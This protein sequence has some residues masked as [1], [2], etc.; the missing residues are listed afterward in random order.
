MAGNLSMLG[1]EAYACEH[2]RLH[3]QA[4]AFLQKYFEISLNRVKVNAKHGKTSALGTAVW[5]LTD[6]IM[7]QRGLFNAEFKQWTV[8]LPDG[9]TGIN[10]N[11]AIDLTTVHGMKILAHECY[12]VQQ[13]LTRP[14]WSSVFTWFGDVFRSLRY[15]RR[16]WSHAQSKWEIEA[17]AFQNDIARDISSRKAEL[18]IFESLR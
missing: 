10:S 18:E 13:W 8:N 16:F 5:V 7:A 12:H 17:I 14:W 4:R 11:R 6:T 15:E 3:P 9:R 2:G 1:V